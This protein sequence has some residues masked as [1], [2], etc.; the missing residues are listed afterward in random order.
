MCAR[1]SAPGKKPNKCPKCLKLNEDG[2]EYC[3]DCGT[4]LPHRK[5]TVGGPAAPAPAGAPKA[6]ASAPKA[7]SVPPKAPGA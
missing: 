3:V 6:P 1:P 4:V 2:V 5:A 7:P